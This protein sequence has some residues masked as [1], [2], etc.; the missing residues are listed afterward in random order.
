MLDHYHR[1]YFYFNISSIESSYNSLLSN[2]YILE[3]RNKNNNSPLSLIDILKDN[4]IQIENQ[5]AKFNSHRNKRAIDVIGSAI[6]FVTG[7][8]DQNDLKEINSNLNALF[9]NQEKIIKQVSKYSS[10]ANHITDRYSKDLSIIKQN[11]NTSFAA[12]AKIDH[13]LNEDILIQY[14]ILISQ[15]L[16][17][18]IYMIQRLVSLAFN[19]LTDLEVISTEEL[20]EILK[21]LKL[22]YKTEE[23]LELDQTHLFKLI[24]FSK[25]KVISVGNIITCILYIPV[26][27]P[28][29]Y[30]YQRIY[31][32]PNAD[33]KL[34]V[35]PSK[36]RLSSIHEEL[37][38]DEQCAILEKQILCVNKPQQSD[39]ALSDINYAEHC[40]CVAARNNY[41]L[42]VRLNNDKILAI[43]KEQFKV[44]EECNGR[45]YHYTVANNVLI[46]SKNDCK[47]MIN[48]VTY[49]NTFNNFTY[50]IPKVYKHKFK[51][52]NKYINLEQKHLDDLS[53][54]KEEAKDL[55]ENIELHPLVHVT[56]IS[57]TLILFIILCTIFII[58]Y[59]YRRKFARVFHINNENQETEEIIELQEKLYPRLPTAPQVEDALS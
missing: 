37:W 14:N 13:N 44:V 34:L 55:N 5:L 26:L 22:I 56:H 49:E 15:K 47:I 29:P 30:S 32:I 58:I 41:K 6:R 16:L 4:C 40:N 46:S 18:T 21:H 53:K 52:L 24:E 48:N 42:F 54:I 17:D 50:D 23:L 9:L 39:C 59:L 1:F 20:Y 28:N 3:L 36:Y 27:N 43:C 45:L 25:M 19:D 8:L 2:A 7:N 11:I 12:I 57:V 33:N 38:T 51:F 10:F 35:P 31:P